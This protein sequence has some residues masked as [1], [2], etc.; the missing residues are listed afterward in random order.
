MKFSGAALVLALLTGAEAG[1]RKTKTVNLNNKGLSKKARKSLLAKAKPYKA[2]QSQRRANDA[3]FEITGD[4]SVQFSQCIHLRTENENMCE[5]D[6]INYAKEG[7]IQSVE[8]FVIFNL[9]ETE[10]CVYESEDNQFIV[11]L[12]D[13]IGALA[14]HPFNVKEQFCKSCEQFDDYCNEE[15]EEEEEAAEEEEGDE[16]EEEEGE[17]E[18]EGDEEQD[19][20]GEEEENEDE[21]G[22]RLKKKSRKAK[23]SRKVKKQRKLAN[24]QRKMEGNYIDC[25]KC[26]ETGCFDEEQEG[27]DLQE[28]DVLEWIQGIAECQQIEDEDNGRKLDEEVAY[29]AGFTCNQYGTGAE[30]AVFVDD[31]CKLLSKKIAFKNVMGNENYA[32]YSMSQDALTYPFLNDI[33]CD[34]T[35]VE[36]D[37]PDAEDEEEQDQNEDEEKEVAESCNNLFGAEI[38]LPLDNCGEQEEEDEQEDEDEDQCQY[39][40]EFDLTADQAEDGV[41][42]CSVVAQYDGEWVNYYKHDDGEDDFEL[43][44]YTPVNGGKSG[45]GAGLGNAGKI[46]LIVIVIAAALGA[47]FYAL[48]SCGGSSTKDSKKERLTSSG[49]TMA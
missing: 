25:D 27:D 35:E 16:A 22:R 1:I 23:K 32:Y 12:G 6:Y 15:E 36:Y 43:Y 28:E 26:W 9:C 2:G 49:G 34:G 37:D 31:E 13:Y 41:A 45:S 5:D 19:E 24:F 11:G 14:E 10:N 21:E 18:E 46:A 8:S 47:G 29:F 17:E 39:T 4:Y 33:D 44:D 38:I 7:S 42:V 3:E 48:K 40:G 20:E 30:I